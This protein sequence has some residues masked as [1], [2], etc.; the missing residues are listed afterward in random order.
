MA[1]SCSNTKSG[2]QEG[3]IEIAQNY[4]RHRLCRFLANITRKEAWQTQYLR[5]AWDFVVLAIASAF[6][7]VCFQTSCRTHS[8]ELP[9]R[10]LVRWALH[11]GT[12]P[13]PY[14]WKLRSS[15][16]SQGLQCHELIRDCARTLLQLGTTYCRVGKN[17][18][19]PF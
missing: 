9:F 19:K 5:K 14:I 11:L 3:E 12:K 10:S 1:A 18:D 16:F 7:C 6:K 2:V 15:S 8:S 13:Q 17:E 4:R